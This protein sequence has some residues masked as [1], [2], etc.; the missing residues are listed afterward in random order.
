VCVCACVRISDRATVIYS[1]DLLLHESNCQLKPRL[2]LHSI[3]DSI[4]FLLERETCVD[5]RNYRFSQERCDK[6]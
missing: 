2:L 5:L 4:P 3:H 1:Y 6:T